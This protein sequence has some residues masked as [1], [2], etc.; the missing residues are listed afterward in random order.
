MSMSL[1]ELFVFLRTCLIALK[2][3]P[4]QFLILLSLSSLIAYVTY[5][6]SINATDDS[7]I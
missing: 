5:P 7:D 3:F 6:F 2:G 4:H 1:I